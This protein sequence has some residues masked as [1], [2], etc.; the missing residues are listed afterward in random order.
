MIHADVLTN[1]WVGSGSDQPID[2]CKAPGPSKEDKYAKT[3]NMM[4]EPSDQDCS[5]CALQSIVCNR[6][7]GG[8]AMGADSTA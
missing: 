5:N 6:R 4:L 7:L 3:A 8:V 2:A 1:S